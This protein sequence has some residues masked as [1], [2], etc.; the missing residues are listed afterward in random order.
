MKSMCHDV[1]RSSPSVTV[2][3]PASRCSAMTSRMHSSST[4]R[5]ASRSI[6]PALNSARALCRRS[7]RSRLPTWSARKGGRWRGLMAPASLSAAAL[8]GLDGPRH[9]AQ[10]LSRGDLAL[11]QDKPRDLGVELRGTHPDLDRLLGP[12][13][14]LAVL[15]RAEHVRDALLGLA[16]ERLPLERAMAA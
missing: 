12:E 16:L 6:C 1:R 5:S 14:P 4:A 7:G 13:A 11:L 3:R 2:F 9:H 15:E 10:R 8:L